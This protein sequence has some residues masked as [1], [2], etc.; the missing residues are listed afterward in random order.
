MYMRVACVRRKDNAE[1]GGKKVTGFREDGDGKRG[2]E[3]LRPRSVFG[4]ASAAKGRT[5][6]VKSCLRAS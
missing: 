2:K 1:N 3:D 5:E 6:R 4:C